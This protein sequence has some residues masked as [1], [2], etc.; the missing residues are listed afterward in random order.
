MK[1]GGE[2]ETERWICPSV[3]FRQVTCATEGVLN[4]EPARYLCDVVR[5][6]VS[7]VM[8]LCCAEI[9]HCEADTPPILYYSRGVRDLTRKASC[10]TQDNIS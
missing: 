2:A 5:R 9:N 10:S 1:A 4:F 6:W 8:V 3:R 7:S